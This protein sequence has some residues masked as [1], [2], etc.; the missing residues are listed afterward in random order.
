MSKLGI[1]S[2]IGLLDIVKQE[3][4]ELGRATNKS[5]KNEKPEFD[6]QERSEMDR[7]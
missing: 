5:L 3:S 2:I 4:I 6:F 1:V 7:L